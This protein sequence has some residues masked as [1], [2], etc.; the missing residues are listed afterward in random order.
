M[1]TWTVSGD[2]LARFVKD[3]K[4]ITDSKRPSCCLF[5]PRPDP[6]KTEKP[7]GT[8]VFRIDE[9][10]RD[11]IVSIGKKVFEN[12]HR[13]RLLGWAKTTRGLVESIGLRVKDEE[14]P[15]LHSDIVGWPSKRDD[16]Y[17]LAVEL[18]RASSLI[19]LSG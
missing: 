12:A 7:S 10:G 19:V 6:Q 5:L 11:E 1:V 2:Q 8:S 13:P 4:H 9:L 14:P 15:P 18:A 17:A 16:Q 3:K